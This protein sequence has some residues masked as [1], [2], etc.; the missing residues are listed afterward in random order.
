MPSRWMFRP[1]GKHTASRPSSTVTTLASKSKRMNSSAMHGTASM[2]KARTMS[3]SP[4]S[5]ACPWP[6]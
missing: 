6:S 5:T 3:S 2:G 1:T 4:R